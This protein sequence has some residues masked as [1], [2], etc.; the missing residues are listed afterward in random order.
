MKNILKRDGLFTWCLQGP[1]NFPTIV[2]ER[3][4]ELAL[5]SLNRNAKGNALRLMRRFT[6]PHQLWQHLKEKYEVDNNPRKVHLIEKFFST[7]KTGSMSMDEYLTEMKETTGLLED[8]EVSL[9]EEVIVW[10]TF[11]NLPKEYDILKHMILCDYLVTT[12]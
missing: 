9:P 2:E 1:S 7:K 8:V 10:N 6:Y 11:K 3:R 12:S 5:S 4:R